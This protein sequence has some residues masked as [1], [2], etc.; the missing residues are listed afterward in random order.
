[1]EQIELLTSAGVHD[2]IAKKGFWGIVPQGL[3]A[4]TFRQMAHLANEIAEARVASAGIVAKEPPIKEWA[5]AIIVL[6]D[7]MGGNGWSYDLMTV[8]LCNDNIDKALMDI[9]SVYRKESRIDIDAVNSLIGTILYENGRR[10]V[11]EAVVAKM[12][13]NAARPQ[14]YGLAKA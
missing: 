1:M 10:A 3:Q 4:I 11:L 14:A 5:D 12:Q 6:L 8:P 13:T 7:M 9:L 2:V